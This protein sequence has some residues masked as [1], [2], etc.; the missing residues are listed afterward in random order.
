MP[1]QLSPTNMA[2]VSA[3][4]SFVALGCGG[5]GASTTTTTSQDSGLP[6]PRTRDAAD[7]SHLDARTRDAPRTSD[8]PPRDAPSP[9]AP[10]R[11]AAAPD[12]NAPDG[13]W[14]DPGTGPWVPVSASDVASK[15]QLD[16]AQL[17]AAD[18]A[19]NVPW[20]IIRHGLLCHEFMTAEMAPSEAWSTTKTMGA[21]V[22]GIVSWQTRAYA[23]T[24]PKTGPFT[25]EDP[26]SNWLDSFSYNQEAHVAHVMAMVAESQSLA[27]GQQQFQYD[28]IG[29]VQINSMSDILNA[30]IAQDPV[31]FGA[32]LE[33]FT[34]RYL[35]APLGMTDSTWSSGSQTKIFAYSW[36]TTVHDMA[37]L[38]LLLL[39]GGMWHGARLLDSDWVYRMTHPSFEDANTG[40]GYL[41]WLNSSS[42]FT[43]GGIPGPPSGMQQGAQLPGPCAP[44]SVYPSHPHGLSESPDCNYAAPYS[45]AQP[46]DVG[47]WQAVG[48]SGQVI[49]GHPGLDIV[50]VA[51][52]LTPLLV[53]AWDGSGMAAPGILWDAVRP[54]I[55]ADDPTFP[56]D[57]TSFCAAY[58]S[59]NYAPSGG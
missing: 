23:K 47:V 18:T 3:V 41:T 56:G 21:T 33:D 30:V 52:N 8:A 22:A 46:L 19:L 7:A 55:V 31:T 40:Y 11:E 6:D 49:Q 39:H 1:S 24:G 45:C 35:Y 54:A 37:R 26:V 57:D 36:S 14:D 51:R 34:Q 43:Y 42:N 15:C 44:V 27:L 29:T 5:E 28:T 2:L 25:D 10:A 16:P 9:D 58:G 38:G 59:N 20:A 13:G 32:G 53:S 12:V 50:I 4:L 48:L 17:A